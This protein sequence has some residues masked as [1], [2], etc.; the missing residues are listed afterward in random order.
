MQDETSTLQARARE[1]TAV[2]TPDPMR[3]PG[4]GPFVASATAAVSAQPTASGHA[5]SVTNLD[6]HSNDRQALTGIDVSSVRHLIGM[7][8]CAPTPF[9]TMSIADHVSAGLRRTGVRRAADRDVVERALRRVVE[10][11][12]TGRP[13]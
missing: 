11:T 9:P 2:L 1:P 12:R 10:P 6:A 8:F 13:S 4:P 3:G 7:V 5:I